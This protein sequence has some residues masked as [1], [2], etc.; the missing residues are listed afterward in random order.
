M[1]LAGLGAQFVPL[2]TVALVLLGLGWSATTVA[3]ATLLSSALAPQ[4]RVEAQGFSDAATPAVGAL[5]AI[6]AGII[7]GV[8]DFRA[9][10]VTYGVIAAAGL[11]VL[12]WQLRRAPTVTA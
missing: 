3:G 8:A 12:T 10:G 7:M 11:L 9:V 5:G 2:V 6:C 1:A 4:D